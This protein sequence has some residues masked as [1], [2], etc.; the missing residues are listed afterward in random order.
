M[1][2]EIGISEVGHPYLTITPET[3]T[4]RAMMKYIRPWMPLDIDPDTGTA[5]LLGDKLPG[6][7]NSVKAQDAT[8]KAV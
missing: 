3:Q 7:G 2:A 4:E 8:S 1:K 5:H 6:S